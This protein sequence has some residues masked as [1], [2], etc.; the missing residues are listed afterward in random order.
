M[1][2]QVQQVKNPKKKINT[3][4][5]CTLEKDFRETVTEKVKKLS[6]VDI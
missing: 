2:V 3:Q 5:N 1:N 6:L 4:E